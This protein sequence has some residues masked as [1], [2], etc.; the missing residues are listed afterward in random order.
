M[1]Q[2]AKAE[3]TD[4]GATGLYVGF[5]E[6]DGAAV[7]CGRCGGTGCVTKTWT[8]FSKKK[9]RRRVKRVYK[10]NPGIN[11][12][13]KEGVCTLE[14]FGGMPYKDW[15]KGK[16]FPPKSENRKYTCPHWWYQGANYNLI[17]K[18]NECSNF[19]G[20]FSDCPN[21]KSKNKCWEKWDKEN[22]GK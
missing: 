17:P 15:A 19:G 20:Y 3:C 7:V 4:C 1:K 18:W 21:F 12:G 11:I 5:G 10:T 13:E 6:R 14:D 9:G 8:E 2:K 22:K 16:P